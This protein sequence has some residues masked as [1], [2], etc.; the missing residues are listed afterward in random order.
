[1]LRKNTYLL[2]VVL[3]LLLPVLTWIILSGIMMVVEEGIS[4]FTPRRSPFFELLGIAVNLLVMRYY[5]VNLKFDKTGRGILVVTF[6]LIIAFFAFYKDWK[7]ISGVGVETLCR[8]KAASWLNITATSLS[9]D[10]L[11]CC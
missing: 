7:Q 5:L 10:S 8:I 11:R 4:G 9:W 2:G 1:M 6:I 3:G